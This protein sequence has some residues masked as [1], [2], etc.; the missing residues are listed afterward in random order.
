MSL[1]KLLMIIAFI[2]QD[3][4]LGHR[5]AKDFYRRANIRFALAFVLG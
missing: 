3:F 5:V 1:F 2:T 4:V